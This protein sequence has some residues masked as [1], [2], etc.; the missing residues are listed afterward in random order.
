MDSPLSSVS[1]SVESDVTLSTENETPIPTPTPTVAIPIP[2]AT[3][4][5]I[6][7]QALKRDSLSPKTAYAALEAHGS[8]LSPEVAL[9]FAKKIAEAAM[10]K[11]DRSTQCIK[12]LLTTHNKGLKAQQIALS[13]ANETIDAMQQRINKLEDQCKDFMF[14][15][16]RTPA[17]YRDNGQECPDGFEENAGR[18]PNFWVHSDGVKLLARYV[19]CIPGTGTIQ[20]TS[21]G[22]QRCPPL[23]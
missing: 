20:G 1:F 5:D 4:D 10:D 2:P 3:A 18:V 8:E 23:P 7:C 17:P 15:Q 9:L 19:K 11:A 21:G 6:V 22:T 14:K 13:S 16:A 12:F